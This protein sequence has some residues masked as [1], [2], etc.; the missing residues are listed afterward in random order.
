MSYWKNLP[1][2]EHIHRILDLI[3][4]HPTQGAAIPEESRAA[5]LNIARE[6]ARQAARWAAWDMA[7][8]DV[9]N[10]A[11]DNNAS[12]TM[13]ENARHAVAALIAWDDCAYILDLHPDVVRGLSALGNEAAVL[14]LP[15]VQ[16]LYEGD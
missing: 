7:W 2:A 9:W 13:R 6:A 4:T 8:D 15:A 3:K 1:N 14:L 5:A 16:A 10:A 11:W 12:P